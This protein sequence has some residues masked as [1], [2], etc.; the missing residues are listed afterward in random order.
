MA[1]RVTDSNPLR[2][3]RKC[4]CNAFAI[5]NYNLNIGRVGVANSG[6]DANMGTA[7]DSIEGL[8]HPP[9]ATVVEVMSN[10]P[11]VDPIRRCAYTCCHSNRRIH[12]QLWIVR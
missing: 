8:L 7:Q 4:A 3:G 2:F 9:S 1:V 12:G 6:R 11:L 5:P 10:M